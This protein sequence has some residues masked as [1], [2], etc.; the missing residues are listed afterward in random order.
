MPGSVSKVIRAGN[1]GKT[2]GRYSPGR[3]L[4]P[5]S[6]SL[7]TKGS[8]TENDGLLMRRFIA[9]I[10]VRVPAEHSEEALQQTRKLAL[11]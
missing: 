10:S 4:L 5:N 8:R 11:Q 2:G 3:T 6:V 1:V 7:P 9:S